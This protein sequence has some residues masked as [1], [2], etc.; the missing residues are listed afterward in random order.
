MEHMCVG[1]RNGAHV[2]MGVQG[3]SLVYRFSGSR[4]MQW[5]MKSRTLLSVMLSRHFGRMPLALVMLG[6]K[7]CEGADRSSINRKDDEGRYRNQGTS[8]EGS[9]EGNNGG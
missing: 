6:N 2:W 9:R 4:S 5:L 8:E 3:G 7:A 1:A